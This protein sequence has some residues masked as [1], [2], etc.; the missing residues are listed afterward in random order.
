MSIGTII[1]SADFT[2][3]KGSRK[4]KGIIPLF[5]PMETAH[6]TYEYFSR[7]AFDGADLSDVDLTLNHDDTLATTA[8]GLKVTLEDDGLHF[9]A[10][11]NKTRAAD[12]AI[13]MLERG[14]IRGASFKIPTA[15]MKAKGNKH[16]EVLKID[17]LQ[18]VSLVNRPAYVDAT[19]VELMR[20]EGISIPSDWLSVEEE[21]AESKRGRIKIPYSFFTNK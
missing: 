9:E 7:S 3:D 19:K 16:Y 11:M 4:V 17:K 21:V 13:N 8:S 15:H 10:D 14:E 5:S 20:S 12:D 2:Y 1:R 18:D 6:G